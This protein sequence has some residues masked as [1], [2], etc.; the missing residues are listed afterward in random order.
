[1]TDREKFT[2]G[3]ICTFRRSNGAWSFFW[4]LKIDQTETAQ[5]KIFSLRK[6]NVHTDAEIRREDV[7][8]VAELKSLP[9]NGHFP[10]VEERVWECVPRV[11]GNM[12]V[13]DDALEGYAIWRAAF[14]RSE[15]GVFTLGLEEI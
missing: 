4:I 5:S 6:F 13:T 11:I 15:A 9:L 12:P 7:A 2:E 10:I 14:D 8:D 1:M 3:D